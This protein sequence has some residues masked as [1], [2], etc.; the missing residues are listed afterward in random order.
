MDDACIILTTCGS[1]ETAQEIAEALVDHA[2]AASCTILPNVRTYYAFEGSTR[3]DDE[4]QL[5]VATTTGAFE[6]ASAVIR[7]MHT[8]DVP[9]ILMVRADGASEAALAW[10]RGM[11]RTRTNGASG[12]QS[13]Q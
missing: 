3:W 2:L 13:R 9:E 10:I 11:G 8:Y 12:E 1:E 7:R 4:F 6:A 5:L